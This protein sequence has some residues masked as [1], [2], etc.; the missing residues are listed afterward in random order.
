MLM[1]TMLS[2]K[3][4]VPV[5]ARTKL[6]SKT[7]CHTGPPIGNFFDIATRKVPFCGQKSFVQFHCDHSVMLRC[8]QGSAWLVVT[9]VWEVHRL[10][11]CHAALGNVVWLS[12]LREDLAETRHRID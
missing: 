11:Y 5:R 1:D 7:K 8:G 10:I 2:V 12:L 6:V 4:I 9:W 3:A